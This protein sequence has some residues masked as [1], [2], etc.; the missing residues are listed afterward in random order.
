MSRAMVTHREFKLVHFESIQLVENISRQDLGDLTELT[1][2]IKASGFLTPLVVSETVSHSRRKS[3]KYDLRAG[4]RRYHVVKE[5]NHLAEI[6]HEPLPFD[7]VPVIVVDGTET[8]MDIFNIQDNYGRL[9]P[10][11]IEVAMACKT[12]K[13]KHHLEPDDIARRLGISKVYVYELLRIDANLHDEIRRYLLAGNEIPKS[14][15]VRWCSYKTDTG[16]PDHG[17][18]LLAYSSWCGR[19]NRLDIDGEKRRKSDEKINARLL[20]REL[21]DW[22]RKPRTAEVTGAIKALERILGRA[23]SEPETEGWN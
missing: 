17:K 3:N 6:D 8:E 11:P 13:I 23:D 18:Q 14:E 9:N 12:L 20:R 19:L 21:R 22:K 4:Y 7:F 5:L 2:V 16:E 1:R 15:L 10:K